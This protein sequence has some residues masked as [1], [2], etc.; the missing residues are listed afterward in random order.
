MFLA[1]SDGA[2]ERGE[3]HVAAGAP[4]TASL[5]VAWS[6]RRLP[7][8]IEPWRSAPLLP[9]LKTTLGACSYLRSGGRYA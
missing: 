5:V 7:Q 6:W 8:S 1:G 9:V 3:S 4:P 2:A